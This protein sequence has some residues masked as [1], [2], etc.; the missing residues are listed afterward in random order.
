MIVSRDVEI[1]D[2]VWYRIGGRARY[3]LDIRCR[4]DLCDAIEFIERTHPSRVLII[5]QGSN[6]IMPDGY[7]DGAV[8][9]VATS[10]SHA[11]RH[12]GDGR[13]EVFGGTPVNDVALR[14]LDDGL[15]G[16]E[17]AGGLPGTV[18][19]AVRGNAGAFGREIE[20]TVQQVEVVSFGQSGCHVQ[21]IDRKDLMFS[22]RESRLKCERE[23]IVSTV[24]LQLSQ[25]DAS[26]VEAARSE[27]YRNI[28][29][30]RI[31]HPME[32]P[33]CGSVFKN[34]AGEPVISRVLDC[35]PDIE[36]KVRSDWHGK[37]A[38]GYVIGRL[39]MAGMR[40][41][42]AQ[43]ST[44][45]HNFIVNR[46]HATAHDVKSL[47]SQIQESVERVL[48]IVPELEIAIID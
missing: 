40:T 19:A 15:T 18:G 11:V 31:R 38:M 33:N 30:R 14:A 22:Y 29:Y 1:S 10:T 5:G 39:G 17:W 42:D 24:T 13:I 9:R 3:L 34:L 26:A 43:I 25:A 2:V 44:K 21:T 32:F 28:A 47:I 6:L 36:Q 41:G 45:H 37:V 35:W 46:G 4:A 27:Y 12:Y 7:F 20:Q 48:G 8:I 16:L 23:R